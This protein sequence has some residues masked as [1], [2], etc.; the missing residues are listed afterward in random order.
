M[1]DS[2]KPL[3]PTLNQGLVS[4]FY[5]RPTVVKALTPMEVQRAKDGTQMTLSCAPTRLRPPDPELFL[6]GLNK[7]KEKA[8]VDENEVI[9]K[10]L[11]AAG[12]TISAWLTCKGISAPIK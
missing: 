12:E 2:P 1:N 7:P 4:E 11:V 5:E 6:K 9:I 8:P 3:R 10:S